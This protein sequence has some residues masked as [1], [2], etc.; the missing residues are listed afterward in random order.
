MKRGD[1]V[2]MANIELV[3]KLPEELYEAYKGRPPML[4]DKGMD[5]IAQSIANGTPL[6]K[7]HGDLIDRNDLLE[8][9]DINECAYIPTIN[10]Y[11]IIT[12]PTIIEAEEE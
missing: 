7:G 12:A 5:M 9:T 11:D 1:E 2:D 4:G 6:P 8:Y 10:R 3:I